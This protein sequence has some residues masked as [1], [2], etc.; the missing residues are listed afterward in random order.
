MHRTTAITALLSALMLSA[1]HA[2]DPRPLTAEDLWEMKRPG[3]AVV[4][5]DGNKVVFEVDEYELDENEGD[6]NLWLL[7]LEEDRKRQL[8]RHEASDS[9]PAWSPD[10]DAI[11]FTSARDNDEAQVMVMPVD[12]GEAQAVTDLPVGASD[13]QWFPDGEQIAFTASIQ[14][15]YG[16]DFD[17]LEQMLEEEDED[18]VSAYTTENR[19][20]RFWNRWLPDER[21]ERATRLFQVDLESEEVTDLMPGH[22]RLVGS[23]GIDYDIHP[24]GEKM[25]ITLNSMPEPYEYFADDI[26]LLTAD[27]SGEKRKLTEDNEGDDS[28]ARFSPDGEFLIFGRQKSLDFYA[29]NVRLVRHDL[30]SGENENLTEELD[31][32]F[33]SWDF[34][35]DGNGLFV[36]AQDR[37]MTSLFHF[38]L[39]A[40]ELEEVYR[41]GTNTDPRS[42]ADGGVVFNHDAFSQPPELFHVDGDG[43]NFTQ[44][45]DFNQSLANEIDFGRVD[46]VTYEGANGE[47]IQM[48]IVYPPDFDED[49]EWPL[50]VQIHGGPHGIFG[51]QFHFRWNANVFAAPGYVVALP[52][53]HGSSSFGQ[54]FAESI[55]G[56]HADKPFRDIMKATDFMEERDYIDGERTAAA[57]GSY[58]GYMTAWIAGQTDRYDALINHAGVY[59]IMGQFAADTTYHREAAYSGAPWDGLEEMNQWNPAMHAENFETPMLI[60]HGEQDYRVQEAQGRE[61]Y[62]VYKGKGLDARLVY[63]PDE[64]HWIQSPQNS[65]HWYGEFEDWLDRFLGAGPQ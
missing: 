50:L 55:H 24:D 57:G 34:D 9:N 60:M 53:F 51:D 30:A 65:V 62:G 4:S 63:Y 5:P 47:E 25:A 36:H 52:N 13:P 11:A 22:E 3:T 15:G 6:T 42:T 33:S 40:G 64:D 38:D 41:G 44:L 61:I 32:S 59:N 31:Y 27:G 49:Q 10:G 21:R 14:P 28:R 37:G 45:T 46:N 7:D 2:D 18:Q 17:K 23:G 12:G 43:E 48:Y 8:T 35:Q 58:G 56:A 39:D 16:G 1:A 54:E 29:D 26:Y 19:T 20:Y